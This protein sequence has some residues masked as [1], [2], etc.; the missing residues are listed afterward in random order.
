MDTLFQ[1]ECSD[2]PNRFR[3]K[4]ISRLRLHFSIEGGYPEIEYD[5]R[6]VGDSAQVKAGARN[7]VTF[8]SPCVRPK[9]AQSGSEMAGEELSPKVGDGG[10]RKG[11]ISWG[12]LTPPLLHQRSDMPCPR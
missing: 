5:R 8:R 4:T 12:C 6:A 10:N 11:G 9:I 2:N 3:N 1:K 7:G